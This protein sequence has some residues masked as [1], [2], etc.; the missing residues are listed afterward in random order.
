M[1]P[2]LNFLLTMFSYHIK[3]FGLCIQMISMNQNINVVI[4]TSLLL[5]PKNVCLKVASQEGNTPVPN[6]CQQ[7]LIAV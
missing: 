3:F 4:S 1:V 5:H 7:N 6:L 2:F